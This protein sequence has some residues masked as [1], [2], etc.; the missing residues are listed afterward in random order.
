MTPR[1]RALLL[2]AAL[3]LTAPM[4]MAAVTTTEVVDSYRSQGYSWIEVKQGP[5]QI[6]VEAVKGSEKVEVVIDIETGAVLKQETERAS[7]RDQGRTGVDVS[8]RDED[9]V[10]RD[11]DDDDDRN[12]DDDDDDGRDDDD[13]DHGRGDDDDDDGRDDDDD[14]SGGHGGGDDDDDHGGDDDDDRGGDDD[15]DHGGDDDDDRGGDDD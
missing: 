4:A 2:S 9:F 1:T 15:D 14:D 8:T 7:T 13:D 10:G 12:D 6:K 5:T 3:V 11:D